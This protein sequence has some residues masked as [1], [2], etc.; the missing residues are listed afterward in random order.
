MTE[1]LV[2]GTRLL[3]AISKGLV[4]STLNRVMAS[5]FVPSEGFV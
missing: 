4:D 1:L 2:A 5:A 3:S